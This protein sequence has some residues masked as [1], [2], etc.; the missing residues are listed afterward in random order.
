[1][2]RKASGI[3]WKIFA[4]FAVFVAVLLTLLWTFQTVFLESFYKTIKSHTIRTSAELLCK[5]IESDDLQ[6][7]VEQIASQNDMGVRVFRANDRELVPSEPSPNDI[8]N[9]MSI[10]DIYLYYR[11]AVNNDGVA[12]EIVKPKVNGLYLPGFM[13]QSS[14]ENMVYVRVLTM[15]D[16]REAMVALSTQITPVG[17]TVYT[18][19]IQLVCI[20]II[21]LLLSVLLVLL[22]SRKI[23]KPIVTLNEKAKSL[24][25]GDY[26]ADYTAHGYREISELGD[27][28]NYAA[29][30]LSTVESLR[31]D[32]LANVSHDLRTP[33]TLITGY[34]QAM[35]DL[36]GEN[37]PENIQIIIDEA[38]RLTLLVNDIMELSKLQSGAYEMQYK[39]FAFTESL[40]DIVERISVL[41]RPNDLNITFEF[42]RDVAILGDEKQLSRVTYNLI[43]NAIQHIGDDKTI[44]VV[45]KI[46][47]KTVRVEVKDNGVGI[48]PEELP[49]IWNRYYKL[50]RTEHNRSMGT[51]LGLSIVQAILKAHNARYGV[52]STSGCGST[53]WYELPIYEEDITY[54]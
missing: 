19:R 54:F 16:G 30:E 39:P 12:F 48:S 23:S 47:N 3:K 44:T 45:Q 21:L 40:R 51:G 32:L 4:Y 29:G 36:P 38:N 50:D 33:L 52:E 8:I 18:L 34:S 28:L 43:Q 13:T 5:N 9:R 53:F 41:T 22:L 25:V 49:H 31:R 1:M 2:K 37:T 20:T 35:R 26:T 46:K 24:A 11:N 14:T 15:S 7:L 17:A 42:D 27:T 6:A 10:G